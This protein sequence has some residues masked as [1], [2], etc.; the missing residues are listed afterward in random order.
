MR[1]ST[2]LMECRERE[3]RREGAGIKKER[4][5]RKERQEEE[6]WR[7]QGKRSNARWSSVESSR[8]KN[9]ESVCKRAKMLLVNLT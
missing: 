3:E 5:V 7:S 6:L 4:G 9:K 1:L 8:E 2:S